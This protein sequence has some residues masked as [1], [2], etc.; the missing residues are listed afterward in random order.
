[1][2]PPLKCGK[3]NIEHS[4]NIRTLQFPLVKGELILRE[5]K[6]L[7]GMRSEAGWAITWVLGPGSQATW[8]RGT[9]CGGDSQRDADGSAQVA[10]EGGACEARGS[11]SVE[12]AVCVRHA[13]AGCLGQA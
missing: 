13:L 1:M 11:V 12:G 3:I 10:K 9:L 7:K 8:G 6:L 4:E 5:V 2:S